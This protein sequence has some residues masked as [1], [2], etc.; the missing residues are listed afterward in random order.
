M[1]CLF[2]ICIMINKIQISRFPSPE[3]FLEILPIKTKS[4]VLF[5]A[6]NLLICF[7]KIFFIYD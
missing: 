1:F 4:Y 6:Y 7:I 5:M 3:F 2:S